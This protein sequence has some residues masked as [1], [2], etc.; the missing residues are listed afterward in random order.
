MCPVCAFH[1]FGA[2]IYTSWVKAHIFCGLYTPQLTF[3]IIFN[4]IWESLHWNLDSLLH[5]LCFSSFHFL[6]LSIHLLSFNPVCT[7]C[8]LMSIVQLSCCHHRLLCHSVTDYNTKKCSLEKK[9]KRRRWG[10]LNWQVCSFT[11][12]RHSWSPWCVCLL[13]YSRFSLCKCLSLFWMCG[14]FLEL[15]SFLF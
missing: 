10:R 13:V 4:E 14:Y 15:R 5:S 11:G 1:I 3:V 8:T 6:F 12:N 7:L 9:R 2:G